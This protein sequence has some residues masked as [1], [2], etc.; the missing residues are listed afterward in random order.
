MTLTTQVVK[1]FSIITSTY[2][3]FRC[4]QKSQKDD[5]RY[6]NLFLFYFRIKLNWIQ[7]Y[8]FFSWWMMSQFSLTTLF[9]FIFATKIVS[10]VA[11]S[12]D[13][14]AAKNYVFLA[15]AALSS[16]P[17]LIQQCLERYKKVFYLKRLIF[18]CWKFL[19]F[20]NF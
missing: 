6:I 15:A 9:L 11:Y 5:D 1:R 2:Y 13:E 18:M 19:A 3:R 20:E 7:N 10:A 14:D 4:K 17:R 16:D 12:Y 8:I